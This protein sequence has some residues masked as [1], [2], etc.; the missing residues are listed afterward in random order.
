MTP[1]AWKPA[2]PA[3]GRLRQGS[4]RLASPAALLALAGL[5]LGPLWSQAG[6]PN[7]ADGLLHLHRCAAVAR[8]WSAG[9]LW[10]RWFPDVYQGLGAPTFH[11][12]SPL[13]Y[14]SVAPLHLLGLPLDLAAKL[15]ITLFFILCGLAVWDW[16]RAL[17]GTEAGLAGA[18]LYLSQPLLYREYYFQ[19]D[20]PQ[21]I[22]TLWA[23][24][25]LWAF[26]RLAR[27]GRLS[28][29]LLAPASLAMLIVA[30]NITAMLCAGALGFYLV[31][32]AL[33]ERRHA[34]WLRSVFAV[35]LALGLSAFFWLP[36]LGDAS[37]VQ[38]S[39]LRRDFFSFHQYFVPWQDLLAAPPALD[40]RA[41]NPPFP[42]M[43]GWS[44]WLALAG[45]LAAAILGRRAH[46]IWTLAG[47]AI[48]LVC[49]ALTQAWSAP[50]W[51][52]LP[53]LALVQF[54]GRLLQPAALGVAL[55]AGAALSSLGRSARRPALLG[56]LLA[57]GLS[58]AVFLFP[59]HT[60]SRMIAYAPA[61]TQ[62][63]E[64][65]SHVWGTTSGNEFLPRWASLSRA[66]AGAPATLL[67]AGASWVWISPQQAELRAAAGSTLPAGALTLPLH[68]FPAW[69]ARAGASTLPA[70]PD[71][72]G[73]LQVQLS[74][75]AE[76]ISVRW[77]GTAWQRWGEW[78]SRLAMLV[79]AGWLILLARRR[80][81]A[82]GSVPQEST[83]P[84]LWAW[85]P[86]ALLLALV[87]GRQAIV[88]SGAG[89]FQRNSPPGV[90][91]QVKHP[92]SVALGG[93]PPAMRLIGWEQLSTAMR[94]GSALRLRLYWQPAG[95]MSQDWHSFVQLYAPAAKRAFAQTQN[96]NPGRI[97]TSTWAP[98]FYYVDDFTLELPFDVPPATFTLVAGLADDRGERMNVPDNEDGLVSLGQVQ[99]YPLQAGL[100]QPV[101]PQ[102]ATPARYAGD[103]RLQGYDL[104]PD[105]GGPI[106]RLYWQVIRRPAADWTIFV[107]LIGPDGRML[108]AFDHLPLDGL[109][110][111]SQWPAGA[112]LIDRSK[113]VLPADLPAGAYQLEV[114]L[115]EPASGQRA[116]VAAES[117]AERYF[118]AGGVLH[119]PLQ[120][121]A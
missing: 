83:R 68:Y 74:A 9:V 50:L 72:A 2:A 96:D 23:P 77:V 34:V 110:P 92:M 7:S 107:H 117:G 12:Y 100:L 41:A 103:L 81:P 43:L 11:Y 24:A 108:T 71:P 105:P 88:W 53:L 62:A 42:H 18:A 17:F 111:T 113:L 64:R 36:A 55:A 79:W 37:L 56:L 16:L 90:V 60:F 76:Q 46:R 19:G 27:H 89:W 3:G 38:I 120:I 101:R 91:L 86:A 95:R 31:V 26:T 39:N 20:Y 32:L 98:A 115:Y 15:V 40:R 35:L 6:L 52:L 70:Q 119:I 54:P 48:A 106:L 114:G 33:A 25:V 66:Q 80:R 13:F 65:Q 59:R 82:L 87:A 63:Y 94:P 75:P 10:P 30:H 97:P 109:C 67:P 102:Q 112:L 93:D 116:S 84:G 121:G 49:L 85:A 57:V 118:D 28:D 104:L 78:I 44:A 1:H 73:L 29:W 4:A 5:L 51:E 99:I 22:A 61:D 45:A 14:L 69:E 58:S 8:A 47:L 21:L